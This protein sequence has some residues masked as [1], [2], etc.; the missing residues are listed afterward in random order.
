MTPALQNLEAERTVLGA[1]LVD[2]GAMNA[3]ASMLVPKQFSDARHEL[4]FEAMLAL[5]ERSQPID[6]VTLRD[7]LA[8]RAERAGG[9]AY[10][11]SLLDGL[12][13]ISH[14]EQY[15]KIILEKARRRALVTIAR[16]A[17]RDASE[18]QHETDELLE[19]HAEQLGRIIS[20]RQE[21]VRTLKDVLPLAL[22][23][24]EAF[25][26][27]PSG[28]VGV[29]SGLPDVDKL[30]GGWRPGALYVVAARPS[31]GKSTFVTQVTLYAA[32]RGHKVLFFGMEMPD[33]DV[34]EKALCSDAEVD[35]WN[36][37]RTRAG[38]E[39]RA[40]SAWDKLGRATGRLSKFGDR[41]WFDSREQ[42]TIGQIRSAARQHQARHGLDLVVVDYLQRCSLDPKYDRWEAVG[43]VAL[44]LKTLA[45]ALQIPVIAACQ[46]TSE[47]EERRPNLGD[48]AQAKQIISQEADVIAFLHP[49]QPGDWRK[50]EFPQ[51]NLL[52]DKHRAGATA[53]IPLSFEKG[54]SRFVCIASS[55]WKAEDYRAKA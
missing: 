6:L 14:P 35:K 46:L 8:D 38:E 12:P 26:S 41:I 29:P 7:E 11:A 2:P 23:Q 39:G 42:P 20:S 17:I 31:R 52:V 22:K 5:Y 3:I 50:Q 51:I 36:D 28:L 33:I 21:T 53:E 34:T 55:D 40:S 43:N 10:L 47:A 30:L 15:A 13:K 48:L 16:A 18:E 37:L 1:V 25:A 44:G 49:D 45:R 27:S 54:C 4:V 9:M 32:S 24:L 19:R